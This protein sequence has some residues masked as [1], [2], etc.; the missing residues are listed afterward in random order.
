M[1]VYTNYLPI[2][3]PTLKLES[4]LFLT[5]MQV[6]GAFYVRSCGAQGLLR[7][8]VEDMPVLTREILSGS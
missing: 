4:H 3:H 5:A 1:K 2:L 6:T 8:V 7:F